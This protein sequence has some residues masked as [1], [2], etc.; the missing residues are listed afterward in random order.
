MRPRSATA[1]ILWPYRRIRQAWSD[2]KK[3]RSMR[4][5]ES[6][7]EG[8]TRQD[9]RIDERVTSNIT[10]SQQ[11][12]PQNSWQYH[13]GEEYPWRLEQ[14]IQEERNWRGVWVLEVKDMWSMEW[15]REYQRRGSQWRLRTVP[16]VHWPWPYEPQMR[17]AKRAE[18]DELLDWLNQP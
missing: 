9:S 6:T 18:P 13:Q 12:G 11:S 10:E 1:T 8:P 14:L 15:R 4:N 2:Y 7:R 16:Q 3:G 17:H 5:G